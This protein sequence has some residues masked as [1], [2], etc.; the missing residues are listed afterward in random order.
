MKDRTYYERKLAEI[1][2]TPA[3]FVLGE[4]RNRRELA[5]QRL[6]QELYAEDLTDAERDALVAAH[7][8]WHDCK[9]EVADLEMANAIESG[10]VIADSRTTRR[11]HDVSRRH[12]VARASII[13][14][15][16]PRAMPRARARRVSHVAR[17]TSSSDSGEDGDP[18]PGNG[19]VPRL[20]SGLAICPLCGDEPIVRPK[21]WLCSRLGFVSRERRNR[22]KRGER[23]P[24]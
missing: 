23:P 3:E 22:Y 10:L 14:R 1:D 24:W 13:A 17:A 9:Q 20:A 4:W 8:E 16:I 15:P 18:E 12:R 21:C 5:E 19:P 7:E 6:L 2:A 11:V